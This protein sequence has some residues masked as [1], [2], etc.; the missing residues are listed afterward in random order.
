MTSQRTKGALPY[1]TNLSVTAYR[2]ISIDFNIL[3]LKGTVGLQ[4]RY[5]CLH[6][7]DHCYHLRGYYLWWVLNSSDTDWIQSLCMLGKGS[8]KLCPKILFSPVL[9][10]FFYYCFIIFCCLVIILLTSVCK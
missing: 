6:C 9:T 7:K 1:A 10:W 3:V 8:T 5:T 4:A 2:P